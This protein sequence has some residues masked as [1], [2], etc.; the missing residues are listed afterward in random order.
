[1][2]AAA[3]AEMIQAADAR[4]FEQ[5]LAAIAA[6][7]ETY[8]ALNSEMSDEDFR[9]ETKGF[10]GLPTTCGSSWSTTSSVSWR[11]IGCSCSCI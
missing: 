7:S 11:R 5:T 9:A 1:M 10:D 3:V 2:D 4:D 8:T 6:H